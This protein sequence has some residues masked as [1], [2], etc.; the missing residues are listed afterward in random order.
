[1][2]YIE[3]MSMNTYRKE[4]LEACTYIEQTADNWLELYVSLREKG[5]TLLPIFFINSLPPVENMTYIPRRVLDGP[6]KGL[7]KNT[8]VT[9]LEDYGLS[10]DNVSN[11][12]RS[13]NIRDRWIWLAYF[14]IDDI[15]YEAV[16]NGYNHEISVSTFS[17][18]GDKC[19]R[20]FDPSEDCWC[21]GCHGEPDDYYTPFGLYKLL[22]TLPKNIG[23]L[24]KMSIKEYRL[25]KP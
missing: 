2:T 24:A 9:F 7:L 23:E 14:K 22:R 15:A 12:M 11:E 4:Y 20:N 5:I 19:R 13:Q 21:T 1:M 6:L 10:L 3:K 17:C 25:F 16:I 18:N 8:E